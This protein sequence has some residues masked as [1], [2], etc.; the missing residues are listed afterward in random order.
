M[1]RRTAF[2][3]MAKTVIVIMSCNDATY[4]DEQKDQR[5][6]AVIELLEHKENKTRCKDQNRSK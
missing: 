6:P 4:C 2:T 5:Q 1:M 3:A